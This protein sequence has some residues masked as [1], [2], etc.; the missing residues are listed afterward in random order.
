MF[1]SPFLVDLNCAQFLFGFTSN[2]AKLL[3]GQTMDVLEAPTGIKLSITQLRNGRS[4]AEKEFDG[5]LIKAVEMVN[6][7]GT[8]IQ[9]QR[10]CQQ[11]A[12]REKYDGHPQRVYRKSIFIPYLDNLISQL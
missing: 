7:C 4:N 11:Q 2:V 1:S 6:D 5:T 8:A 10:R 9:I 3:Q 12:N